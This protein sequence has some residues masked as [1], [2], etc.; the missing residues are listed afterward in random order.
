MT[1]APVERE[2]GPVPYEETH[3]ARHLAPAH[4]FVVASAAGVEVGRTG[5]LPAAVACARAH[6]VGATVRVKG[7][8]VVLVVPTEEQQEEDTCRS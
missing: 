7:Q 1:A 8:V 6:G 3:R 5:N 4:D 2:D